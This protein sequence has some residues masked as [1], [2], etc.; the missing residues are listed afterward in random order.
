LLIGIA[1]GGLPVKVNVGTRDRSFPERPEVFGFVGMKGTV[2]D[3]L[4]AWSTVLCVKSG[5]S[6]WYD[7]LVSVKT[8]EPVSTFSRMMGS[9][10]F[11]GVW[12]DLGAD[13]A[14]ALN[15]SQH[16]GFVLAARSGNDTCATIPVPMLGLAADESS[17]RFDLAWELGK[18]MRFHRDANPM[19]H[20]PS[21]HL[22]DTE[23]AIT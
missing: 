16:R 18:G 10:F 1:K 6:P 14:V 11:L 8:G 20:A 13:C 21:G 2:F 12:D 9:S 7:G 17:V 4:L 3:V 19:V 5:A 22:S 23:R 15:D